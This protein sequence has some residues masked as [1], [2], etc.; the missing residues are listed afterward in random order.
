MKILSGL[1]SR[2]YDLGVIDG[3]AHE[4]ASLVLTS[5]DKKLSVE[6]RTSDAGDSY[7]L[8]SSSRPS[9]LYEV[10]GRKA[11]AAA[12]RLIMQ[13]FMGLCPVKRFDGRVYSNAL[14]VPEERTKNGLVLSSADGTKYLLL[15]SDAGGNAGNISLGFYNLLYDNNGEY[16]AMSMP[17]LYARDKTDLAAVASQVSVHSVDGML[18]YL[19]QEIASATVC[20][21]V[22]AVPAIGAAITSGVVVTASDGDNLADQN[23]TLNLFLDGSETP[24]FVTPTF[25]GKH[26]DRSD[27]AKDITS[28]TRLQMRV[29]DN[30]ALQVNCTREIGPRQVYSSFSAQANL[31]KVEEIARRAGF[32]LRQ[33]KSGVDFTGSSVSDE[34]GRYLVSSARFETQDMPMIQRRVLAQGLAGSKAAERLGKLGFDTSLG[35]ISSVR[36]LV[37]DGEL[38]A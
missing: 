16:W 9:V 22:S 8:W 38:P 7:L 28:A 4:G 3:M 10:A 35:I 24:N 2:A 11:E 33:L 14:L 27:V 1:L 36:Q 31:Y 30:G 17:S 32:T 23:K 6:E 21:R 19:P 12:G 13:H 29:M 34:M 20:P 5:G 25:S 37:V 18:S 15:S 26:V